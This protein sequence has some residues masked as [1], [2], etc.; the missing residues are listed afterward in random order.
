MAGQIADLVINLSADSRSFTEQMGRVE[1]QLLKVAASAD[2]TEDNIRRLA[3]NHSSAIR[4]AADSTQATLKALDASQVFCADNFVRKWRASAREI[5]AIHQ[6]INAQISSKLHQA[7]SA[8]SQAQQQDELTAAFFRQIDTVKQI[9][10]G[11]EKLTQIRIRLNQARDTGTLSQQNHLV[12]L[13]ATNGQIKKLRRETEL[14]SQQ[15]IR[16]IQR[17]KEQVATQNLSHSA[18]LRFQAAQLGVG[19]SAEIYIRKLRGMRTETGKLKNSSRFL[20]DGLSHLAGQ[21]GLSGVLAGGGW[22]V[23]LAVVTGLGKAAWQAEQEFTQ[24]N[25]QLILTGN[26]ANKSASQLNEMART[27]SGNGITRNEMAVTIAKVTGSGFFRDNELTRVSKA[28]AQMEYMT[29]QSV[30]TTINQFKRLQESPLQASLELEKAN[31]HLTAAQLEQIRTLELQGDKTAAARLAVDAY[32]QSINDGTNSIS[33][34]LGYLES[35]WRSVSVVAG[36]AWDAMLGAGRQKTT[37]EKIRETEE[38]LKRM[39]DSPWSV[40]SSVNSGHLREKL[41]ILKEQKYQES[42]AASYHRA[43]QNNEQNEINRIRVRQRVMEQNATWETNRKLKLAELEKNRWALTKQEYEDAK[44]MINYKLRDRTMPGSRHRKSHQVDKKIKAEEQAIKEQV[45]LESKLRVLKEYK[46]V[47]EVISSER[48]NLWETEARIAVAEEAQHKRKLTLEEQHLLANKKAILSQKE[49]LAI[50]GDEIAQEER[51]ADIRK[52]AAQH[53]DQQNKKQRDIIS[54]HGLSSRE[55]QRVTELNSLHDQFGGTDVHADVLAKQQELYAT[56]DMNRADWLAGAQTA[57]GDYRDAALDSHTQIQNV[58]A[59]TLNGFSS[60]LASV[61]TTGKA[62]FREFATSVLKMLADI[63]VK[64]SL[65]MTLE[66]TGFGGLFPNA[67][68]GVYQSPSLSAYSGQVVHTP[69]MFAFARGA[70]LMG[71]AGPEGI[72]PL[73]RGAD[74]KLGVMAKLSGSGEPLVQNNYVT[75]NNEGGNGQIGPQETKLILNLI[76]QK[77]KQVMATERRPGG[78]MG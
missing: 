21:F 53:T 56:E 17:L 39:S 48:K 4:Q 2:H 64:K 59:F 3:G 28:A 43:V 10:G 23:A 5:E 38:A 11:L 13:S 44:K 68:G 22:A 14:L 67:R 76:E 6:R 32:A 73:R 24:F 71:E 9:S 12:L 7:G 42:G 46:S 52:R 55:A 33:E 41:A 34:N 29:G 31:H 66:A 36:K 1:R 51:L 78:S 19:S 26:Y 58:A 18:M 49:K 62:N 69:T 27:L 50:I 77:T 25:K 75:I 30:E 40:N 37:D 72:F 61:L 74:G 20:A 47:T 8:K 16:F 15:R 45:A 35:A 70:G 65:V 63:F 60:E 54:T 57:W